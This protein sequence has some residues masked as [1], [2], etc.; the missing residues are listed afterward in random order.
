MAKP[1][2]SVCVCPQPVGSPA[3]GAPSLLALP[4]RGTAVVGASCHHAGWIV[5]VAAVHATFTVGGKDPWRRD[6]ISCVNA[7]WTA[8]DRTI[9]GCIATYVYAF[10]AHRLI[11]CSEADVHDQRSRYFALDVRKRGI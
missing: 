9:I 5:S 11:L 3:A 8:I 4:G 7:R 6:T 2:Q 10:L 1:A